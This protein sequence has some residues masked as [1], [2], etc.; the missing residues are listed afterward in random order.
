LVVTLFFA[1]E[2]NAQSSQAACGS[3]VDLG[4]SLQDGGHLY[5]VKG[6]GP[7][8]PQRPHI[9][10]DEKSVQVLNS[11]SLLRLAEAAWTK[12][13]IADRYNPSIGSGQVKIFLNT[14]SRLRGWQEATD[15]LA[16]VT[17]DVLGVIATGVGTLPQTIVRFDVNEAKRQLLD[18][19]V[20]L[21]RFVRAGL[22]RSLADYAQMENLLRTLDRTNPRVSD[23]QTIRHYYQSA[24][25]ISSVAE[26]VG[27][28]V[29]PLSTLDVIQ[30]YLSSARQEGDQAHLTKIIDVMEL[31]RFFARSSA[32][33]QQS[34]DLVNRL[35]V[36]NQ[37][38]ISQWVNDARQACSAAPIGN[39]PVST[40]P[41]L[42]A[43]HIYG[44]SP[45]SVKG[46]QATALTIT[47]SGFRSG[48]AISVRTP[49]GMIN[50]APTMITVLSSNELRIMLTLPAAPTP[51]I[52][53]LSI[54]IPNFPTVTANLQ[55]FSI[56]VPAPH[57]TSTTPTS[58]APTLPAKPPVASLPAPAPVP[59]RIIGISPAQV[60]VG[61]VTTLTL[62]GTGF[63]NG[64]SISVIGGNIVFAPSIS[65]MNPT[66]ILIRVAMKGPAPYTCAL[67]I[68]A[69]SGQTATATLQVVP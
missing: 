51:Y 15:V 16:R 12:E 22:E 7:L 65:S 39:T 58:G 68:Q 50:V 9:F 31:L 26:A 41:I 11:D 28:S 27:A 19:G 4:Y 40:Q 21:G 23:L 46:M 61:Q 1:Q 43:P 52:A 57:S 67:R 30:G 10:F 36:S 18:P 64:S 29:A 69:P 35:N 56:V 24:N 34:L 25:G 3:Y 62:T 20:L 8:S 33:L 38:I 14:Y 2:T 53:P 66:S 13:L 49:S 37:G 48:M 6:I 44:I 42:V 63:Q 59:L 47:G 32:A 5:R 54:S 17:V 45:S 60:H 55:V